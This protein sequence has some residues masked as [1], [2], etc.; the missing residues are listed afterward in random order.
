MLKNSD[1]KF[2]AS[3]ADIILTTLRERAATGESQV[4]PN[5]ITYSTVISTWATNGHFERAAE[6]LKDMYEDYVTGNVSAKPDLQCF[7][8]VLAAF[9]RSNQASAPRKAQEFF[10]SMEKFAND[11]VLH[12]QPDVYSFTSGKAE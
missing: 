6:I 10:D 9:G 2:S 12:V 11:G 8:S 7:N 4:R 3:K 1:S 5:Y